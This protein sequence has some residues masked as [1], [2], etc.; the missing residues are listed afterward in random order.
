MCCHSC[1]SLLSETWFSS[2]EAF[3]IF[4]LAPECSA[5]IMLVCFWFWL[6]SY[7][8]FWCLLDCAMWKQIR[9]SCMKCPR[10]FF[11]YHFLP[12]L[13]YLFSLL[14][15]P[16]NRM[17]TSPNR[18]LDYLIF[19]IFVFVSATQEIASVLSSRCFTGCFLAIRF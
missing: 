18:F 19:L 9:V 14:E 15:T 2:L 10:M 12:P 17:L 6:F 3:R 1:S 16:I 13:F 11:L 4:S 5:M 7:S 8:L